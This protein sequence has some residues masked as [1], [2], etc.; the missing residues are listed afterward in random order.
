MT[1][2][3]YNDIQLFDPNQSHTISWNLG[4]IQ[5]F[6]MT[7][8]LLA[9]S[10]FYKSIPTNQLFTATTGKAHGIMQDDGNFVLYDG[11]TGSYW[12]TNTNGF[13]GSYLL[14][15][16]DGNVIVFSP[17]FGKAVYAATKSSLPC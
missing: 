11:L 10:L 1:Y 16:G 9:D 6:F 4:R 17:A 15:Q 14:L 7:K 8:F 5:P 12:A 13:S 3:L 2:I